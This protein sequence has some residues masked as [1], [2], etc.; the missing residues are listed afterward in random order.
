MKPIDIVPFVVIGNPQKIRKE[1]RRM[2]FRISRRSDA[3]YFGPFIE[4][5]PWYLRIGFCLGPLILEVEFK[6]AFTKEARRRRHE[7]E[8]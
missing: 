6:G 8:K 7:L 4:W 1:S 3:F 2:E 5:E